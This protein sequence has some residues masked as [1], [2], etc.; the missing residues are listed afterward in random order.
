[1]DA[2]NFRPNTTHVGFADEAYWNEG[3]FRSVTLVSMALSDY[4]DN[5]REIRASRKSK[6]SSELKW[7]NV[8]GSRKRDE[9]D[10]ICETVVDIAA[11]RKLRVDTVIWDRDDTRHGVMGRDDV[12]NLLHMYRFLICDVLNKRWG[13]SPSWELYIDNRNDLDF[14][15]LNNGIQQ[16]TDRDTTINPILSKNSVMVQVADMF[17]GI[18][19]YSYRRFRDYSI[20]LEHVSNPL[21]M[22]EEF[23]PDEDCS[24]STD[25]FRFPI[26]HRIYR[27]CGS[28]RM[29]L[30]L[31]TAKEGFWT[32]SPNEPNCTIN[33]WF[34]I[35]QGDYD[36]APTR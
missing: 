35:P 29:H 33:F 14:R 34:Y 27:R 8:K 4:E 28:H 9:A 15:F 25:K 11:K 32:R 17:A 3:R 1:M 5:K 7:Q 30:S 22:F 20:W 21:P 26:M 19:A 31:S 6:S 23:A 36:E 10:Y 16:R 18:G 12:Q 2:Y 24:S 13:T